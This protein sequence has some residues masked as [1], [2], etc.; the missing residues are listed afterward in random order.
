MRK[1]AVLLGMLLGGSANAQQLSMSRAD[2]EVV[3]IAPGQFAILKEEGSSVVVDNVLLEGSATERRAD[4]VKR[5]RITALNEKSVTSLARFVAEYRAIAAGSA[6]TL[7]L[8]RNDSLLKVR[9][10]KPSATTGDQR[11]VAV[12]DKDGA[13][14]GAWATAG[15][16]A[17][18]G[19][20]RVVIA[21]VHVV[22]NDQGMPEVAHRAAHP[23]A[24]TVALRVG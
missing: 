9:F 22:E 24:A 13:P 1:S 12:R 17:A 23:A 10:T 4:V 6:V 7:S 19:A 21:G 11:L 15:A 16:G 2:G 5:D 20:A 8:T 3:V 18:S 14:A